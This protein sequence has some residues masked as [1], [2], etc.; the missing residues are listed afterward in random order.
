[1]FFYCFVFERFVCRLKCTHLRNLITNSEFPYYAR[2]SFYFLWSKRQNVEIF[3][4]IR[5]RII[6]LSLDKDIFIFKVISCIS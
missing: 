3:V 4:E 6:C 1:M 2:Q 5:I